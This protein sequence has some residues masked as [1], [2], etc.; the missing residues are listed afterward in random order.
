MKTWI[1]Y[2]YIYLSLNANKITFCRAIET[3]LTF[4]RIL[5]PERDED[6][7]KYRSNSRFS[8][9]LLLRF[10][11]LA[12]FSLGGNRKRGGREKERERKK[13]KKAEEQKD[14]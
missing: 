5:L 1:P 11:L 8:P 14:R 4:I 10:L 9:L 7:K 12:R 6:Q 2:I 13:E 3:V